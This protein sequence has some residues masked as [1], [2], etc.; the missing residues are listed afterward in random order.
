M[1]KDFSAW[2]DWVGPASGRIN[3]LSMKI[4]GGSVDPNMAE[5]FSEAQAVEN[6]MIR[7]ITGAQMSAQEA[8]RIKNQLPTVIDKPEVFMA[9]L[10]ATQRNLV[11]I[12]S[13]MQISNMG[14][15]PTTRPASGGRIRYD[16][17]G[18]RIP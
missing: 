17:S 5:F 10:K 12:I 9:K 13:A 4:P 7:A 11:E 16:T 1:Q 18:N 14:S 3:Q 6:R 15:A 2:K 8:A